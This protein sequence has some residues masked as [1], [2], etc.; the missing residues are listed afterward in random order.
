MKKY[1]EIVRNNKEIVRN[2]R[3]V[4]QYGHVIKLYG[5]FAGSMDEAQGE[6]C[7]GVAERAILRLINTTH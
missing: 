1:K 3:N 4:T 5:D 7:S 2:V 6:D